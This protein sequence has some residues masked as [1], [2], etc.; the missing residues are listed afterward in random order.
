MAARLLSLTL[1][2]MLCWLAL[3][4]RRRSAL[5]AETL[6]LRHEVTVLRRQLGPARPSWPDR[7]ILSALARILPHELR[8]HRLV[9]PATLLAW[10]RRLLTKKWTYPSRPGR[11]RI[12]RKLRELVVR[13][14][15]ENPRW[16]HR[17]IQGELT[18][19]GH[20]LGAGT[21]PPHPDRRTPGPGTARDRHPLAHL[22]ASPGSRVA[23]HRLLPSRHPRAAPNL[24]A[25]RHRNRQPTGP[26]PRRHRTPN[27][28]VD[29][30]GRP[31]P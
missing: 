12:D 23:G 16:G 30:A 25:V 19:L 9:T 24:R 27:D 28:G 13:L 1:T 3:L 29:H 14:A 31:Q 10:H 18:R 26:P 4:C 15:R 22:P 6:T 7:P 5:I 20:R 11:P 8:R 2:R 21:I 17:R